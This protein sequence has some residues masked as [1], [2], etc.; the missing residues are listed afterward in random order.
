MKSL[1]LGLRMI[2]ASAVLAVLVA[3]VFAV[4]INAVSGLNDATR[5]EAHAKDVT[6]ATLRLEKLVLDLDTGVRGYILTGEEGFLKPFREARR[7]L[8]SGRLQEFEEL[9]STTPEQGQRARELTQAIRQYEQDYAVN[10]LKIARANPPAARDFVAR[11]EG[12]RR[13]TEIR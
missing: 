4:L 1:S 9:A 8:D 10:V 5:R 7:D 11:D 3:G 13:T 6:A 12:Q 2:F